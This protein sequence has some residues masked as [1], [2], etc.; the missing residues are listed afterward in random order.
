[1]PTHSKAEHNLMEGIAHG[2]K[3]SHMKGK[4]PPSKK[5]AMEMVDADDA[6]AMV[7]ELRRGGKKND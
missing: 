1:M 5:V 3:P 4:K 7:H 6:K 2:W